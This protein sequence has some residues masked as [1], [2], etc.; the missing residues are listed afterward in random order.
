MML[1]EEE[2]RKQ[3]CPLIRYCV[4]EIAVVNDRE[5]AIYVHQA[6]QAS[7]C[8]IGWR[9]DVTRES[10]SPERTAAAGT[11]I[12]LAAALQP[13]TFERGYCGAFGR[14]LVTP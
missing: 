14:P 3:V 10:L 5:P 2:A 7:D 13:I 12:G 8:K 1:T 4:N 11:A 9:W 6:C